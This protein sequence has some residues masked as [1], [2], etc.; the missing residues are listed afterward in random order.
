MRRVWRSLFL[1]VVLVASVVLTSC[2]TIRTMPTMGSYDAPTVY[3]G[4]RLD[5]CGAGK[6]ETCHKRFSTDPPEHPLIDLPFS[7]LLDTVILPVTLPV[8]AY[9]FVFGH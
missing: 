3:S 2:G 9:E 1:P 4:T 8:V 5:A 7:F 6:S